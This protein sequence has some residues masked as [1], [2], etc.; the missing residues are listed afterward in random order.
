MSAEWV[1]VLSDEAEDD[2]AKLDNSAVKGVRDGI[3]KLAISPELRGH[4]LKGDLAGRR[5]LV[6]GKKK[7]RIIFLV[8]NE[9]VTVL[10]IG[11]GNRHNDEVY[12]IAGTRVGDDAA[13]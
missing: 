5:S 6:V 11:I 1:V 3:R 12:L 2:L 9:T 4:P 8:Q 10:I 7:I 13:K